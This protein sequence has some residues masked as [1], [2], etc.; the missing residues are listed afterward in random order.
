MIDLNTYST[1][2]QAGGGFSFSCSQKRGGLVIMGDVAYRQD[3]VNRKR[4][5]EYTI[6]H[7]RSW[8]D[9]AHELGH[10]VSL[11]DL[12]LVTGCDKTSEWACAAWSENTKS[13]KATFFAGASFIAEGSANIWGRWESAESLDKNVG[14]QPL[15]P[16]VPA[17]NTTPQ[18]TPQQPDAMLIDDPPPL[19]IVPLIAPPPATQCVFVRGYRMG[20][21]FKRRKIRIDV[22]SGFMTVRKPLDSKKNE[23]TQHDTGRQSPSLSGAGSSRSGTTHG[24]HQETE[25]WCGLQDQDPCDSHDKT[26]SSLED[27]DEVYYFRLHYCYLRISDIN[28]GEYSC[29]SYDWLHT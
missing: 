16:T 17:V 7:H 23:K 1:P 8:L 10:D 18:V 5:L 2:G 19:Q 12:I 4:F 25:S 27:I 14:P 24:G 3:V 20:S 21:W 11:S 13:L 6:K 9:F 15:V 26:T 29:G 28:V 22:G